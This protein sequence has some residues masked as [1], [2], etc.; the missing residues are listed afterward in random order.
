MSPAVSKRL[1]KLFGLFLKNKIDALLVSSWPNVSYLSGFQGTESWIVVSPKARFFI[2]DSRY[3][4]QADAEAK[5]FRVILRDGLSVSQIVADLAAQFKW[6]TIGFEAAIVTH[7]FY[8]GILKSLGADRLKATFGLVE[9]LREIKDSLE[10]ALI[11]E[12]ANIAVKG[13]HYIRQIARPG[14]KERE[15]QARL[16]HYTK[17]LGSDKPAFDII[18]AA[19]KRSSMPHCQTNDTL[20]EDNEILLV[21]M[22]VVYRGYHSDLTRPIFLGRMNPSHKK[23]YRIVWDAQRAGIAQAGPGVPASAVDGACREFIRKQGYEKRFGHGTGHGVGLEIHEAPSVSGRSRT[24][25]QPGMVITVEPG[26]YLPGKFG[27]RIED[28]V[29]ITKNGHEVLTRDLDIP[30]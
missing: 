26:I 12:S 17:T 30:V 7:S 9:E 2:T 4:E 16:E 18:I 13:F 1:K 22:G 23:I 21:D 3:S 19:G 15:L 14:M 8:L 5:G 11:R 24:I 6:K 27:V 28:M 29:L 25:L 20:T 10:I